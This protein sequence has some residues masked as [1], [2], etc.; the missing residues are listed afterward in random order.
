[1]AVARDNKMSFGQSDRDG[2]SSQT[3]HPTSQKI[4]VLT[5]SIQ[6]TCSAVKRSN[7]GTR[8][9]APATSLNCFIIRNNMKSTQNYYFFKPIFSI[10]KLMN[11]QLFLMAFKVLDSPYIFENLYHLYFKCIF[12][13]FN[14]YFEVSVKRILLKMIEN[15]FSVAKNG[16]IILER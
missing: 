11:F 2:F 15:V 7:G 10:F 12:P 14:F 5:I 8:E 13:C 3:I 4:F 9:K 6:F 16:K 1:M